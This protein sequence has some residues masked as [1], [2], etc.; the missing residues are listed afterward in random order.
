MTFLNVAN[1]VDAMG[2]NM[3]ALDLFE[4]TMK[5]NERT[6]AKWHPQTLNCCMNIAITH[7]IG[8]RS[9]AR[10]EELYEKIL[11]GRTLQFGFDHENTRKCVENYEMCLKKSRDYGRLAKLNKEFPWLLEPG[12]TILRD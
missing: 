2:E 11:V 6:L 9:F 12:R 8:L 7:H 3:E 10:A 5:D 4:S 1:A